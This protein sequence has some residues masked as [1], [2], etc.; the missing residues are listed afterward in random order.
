MSTPDW[1][2]LA[3]VTWVIVALAPLL[4]PLVVA[5]RGG[6]T[7][8]SRWLF[9]LLVATSSYGVYFLLSG[10]AAVLFNLIDSWLSPQ[11]NSGTFTAAESLLISYGYAAAIGVA[12][13]LSIVF[14]IAITRVLRRGWPAIAVRSS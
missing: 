9:V 11:T 7:M 13:L 4:I 3:A 14:S 2:P 12:A 5:V 10:L 8:P 6:A 1:G